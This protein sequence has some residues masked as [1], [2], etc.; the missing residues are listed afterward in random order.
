M[1]T[2]LKLFLVVAAASL[3]I[4]AP[5]TAAL[6]DKWTRWVADTPD[7]T[8]RSLD[9][10][11]PSLFASGESNGVFN[12]PTV[13]GPWSQQNSGLASVPAQSVRQIKTSPDGQLY[14]A[15]SAG[16]FRSG[17]GG[18]TSWSP[19]GQGEGA[20]K[21]NMGGVQTIV[22]NDPTG[23][24]MVVGVA[25]AGGAGAY[26][27][28]DGGA[29]WDRASGMPS[30]QSVYH[31]TTGPAG[32]PIYASADDGVWI[33]IDFGRSWIL[34]SDGIPPGELVLRV[35][36][37]PEDP[38]HLYAST[39]SGVYKS[40]TGGITWSEVEGSEGQTLP[41]AGGKRAFIL[42]PSLNGQFGDKHAIVGTENGVWATIDDG[43]HWGQMSPEAFPDLNPDPPPD[44][45]DPNM[46]DRI[47]WSLGLGFSPPSLMAGTAGFGIFAVPLQPI[48]AGAVNIAPVQSL[49]P[50]QEIK[51]TLSGWGGTRPY[52]FTYQWKKCNSLNC[53]PTTPIPGATSPNYTIP[54]D[55]AAGPNIRYRVTVSGRNL[56]QPDADVVD[57]GPTNAGVAA[58]P[59]T[60]P[61]PSFLAADQPKLSP[62]KNE[63]GVPPWGTV[64]TI[65]NGKW[66]TEA[67]AN[68]ITPDSFRYRWQRCKSN[69]CTEI[70]GA[71]GQTYTTNPDDITFSVVGFV[72]GTKGSQSSEYF[73]AGDSATIIN[74]FPVSTSLPKIVG[75]AY[76]G[77]TLSSSAGGWDGYD[78]T[79]PRRWL[80]CEADGLGCNPTN[81]PVTG[82]TYTITAA[83]LGKRLQLEVKATG[84]DGNQDRV[85]T[86]YSEATPVI[87]E[88]P[89]PPP[90][91]GNGNGNG[92]GGPGGPG[93]NGN[94]NGGPGG[95]KPVIKIKKPRKVKVGAKLSVPAKIAGFKSASYQWLRNGKRIKGATKRVYKI[96]RADRG[97]KIACRLT[98]KPGNVKVT[99]KPVTVPKKKRR[100]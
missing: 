82:S 47:V 15:T 62:T 96:R 37:A 66:R 92:N 49:K 20:R 36:V 75:D 63:L 98:L 81:P 46:G 21:L 97:K 16:L 85:T 7:T 59:G 70:A 88:P 77:V 80:R 56:V 55:D 48:E 19:V 32:I 18:T 58:L 23:Q 11:G 45:P 30:V 57:S 64:Y 40:S 17:V 29:H 10:I 41:A 33:S 22:F 6:P 76:T 2:S 31:M 24:D 86:A 90:G 28:S 27:S 14:A 5:A 71:T 73:N 52:F 67:S 78:M 25:G 3:S 60:N 43:E 39:S 9:F 8:I 61:R 1:R 87:T 83:D 38:S 26:Y 13:V 53:N 91:G 79:F 34:S 44:D 89:P 35:A 100:R 65:A 12:S 4:A 74:K 42:A 51:S 54:K 72:A 94:G 93:G 99:T 84:E 95:T 50:G 69:V 68:E